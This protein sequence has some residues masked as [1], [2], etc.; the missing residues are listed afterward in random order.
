ME[1]REGLERL[2]LKFRTAVNKRIHKSHMDWG[3]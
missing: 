2:R 1:K 3:N